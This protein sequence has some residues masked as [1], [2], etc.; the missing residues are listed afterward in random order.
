MRARGFT[1]IEVLVALAIAGVTVLA[2]HAGIRTVF[3]LEATARAEGE[4]S[5]RALAVRRQLADWLRAVDVSGG[6][7]ARPLTIRDRRRD[8][9]PDDELLVTTLRPSPFRVGRT[10]LRLYIDREPGTFEDGLVAELE[11]REGMRQRHE[12]APAAEGLD[13]RFLL[14]IEHE[15]EWLDTWRSGTQLPRAIE[16]R[17]F[18]DSLPPLLRAPVIVSLVAGAS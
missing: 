1:L 16:I 11:D 4:R 12:L 15:G 17:L 10:P 7:G 5:A 13:L 3:D 18:G 9:R 8:G 14:R 2:V 6:A